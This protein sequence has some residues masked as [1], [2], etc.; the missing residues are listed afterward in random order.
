MPPVDRPNRAGRRTRAHSV[1]TRPRTPGPTCLRSTP[2]GPVARA[3]AHRASDASPGRAGRRPRCKPPFHRAR[4]VRRPVLSTR[5]DHRPDAPPEIQDDPRLGRRRWQPVIRPYDAWAL[6]R[7]PT[8]RAFNGEQQA[9]SEP[10]RRVGVLDGLP[11][12]ARQIAPRGPHSKGSAGAGTPREASDDLVP[13]RQGLRPR[14]AR[15]GRVAPR[16]YLR[17]RLGARSDGRHGHGRTTYQRTLCPSLALR[18][19]P[20]GSRPVG[21][22]RI[23]RKA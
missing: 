3:V 14:P 6:S 22:W 15:R 5:P 12:G 21:C 2:R 16:P 1:P 8:G 17:D 11:A 13:S 20:I 19:G 18:W 10:F 9:L 4:A 23:G 7:L